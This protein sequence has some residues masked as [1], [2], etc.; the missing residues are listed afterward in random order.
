M[1]MGE[2]SGSAALRFSSQAASFQANFRVSHTM[3]DCLGGS[4]KK[5]PNGSVFTFR[6]PCASS[7]SN[8]YSAPS[9]TPGTKI[10]QTPEDPSTR[11]AWRRPSQSLKVPMTETRRAFGAQTANAVPATP[12]S[13]SSCAPRTSPRRRWLPSPKR[14]RS[15]SPTVGQKEYG[16]RPCVV[17]PSAQVTTRS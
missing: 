12:S 5:A 4:S 1:L 17:V 16:S 11:I 10:S 2:R 3:A 13:V 9:P 7:I 8:L 14:C 6:F 15:V